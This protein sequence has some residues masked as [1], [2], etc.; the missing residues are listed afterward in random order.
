MQINTN[1]A[2]KTRTLLKTTGGNDEPN[3]VC[4]LWNS[5]RTLQYGTQNAK[6]YNRTA[7][8]TKKMSHTEPTEDTQLFILIRPQPCYS[9]IQSSL[10]QVLAVIEKLSILT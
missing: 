3:T 10:V 9:Y 2:H 4:V 5:Q 7:Q 8:K 1:N 6:T